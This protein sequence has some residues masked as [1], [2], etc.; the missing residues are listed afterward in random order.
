MSGQ[1]ERVAVVIEDDADIRNLLEAI[2]AQ[3]GFTCHSAADGVEGIAAVRQ[4]QPILTTLDISLPGIDGFEV[5]RRIRAFSMTYIVMLSAR[6]EEIDTLMGLD[7]GADDYLTKPFRPRELRA[8]IEAMLRRYHQVQPVGAPAGGTSAVGGGASGGG[9]AR[10]GAAAAGGAAAA[11]GS[12]KATPTRAN[13]QPSPAN[14]LTADEEESGWISHNGLRINPDMWLCD[15]DGAPL[16]LTRSEFDLLLAI[17]QGQRRVLSKD[18]LAL[19]LRGEYTTGGYVSDSDRRAVEVHMA[20]LRRKLND[21][22]SKP[23]YI[24]TVRGVGY[25]LAE[26]D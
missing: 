26:P 18:T 4:H 8:R 10:A 12:T 19:E 23:R 11:A 16:E 25:R 2:L 9:A 15:L 17:M 5:A 7:A 24:E 13:S 6:D 3:A 21:P 22:V 1:P 14:D 20:N